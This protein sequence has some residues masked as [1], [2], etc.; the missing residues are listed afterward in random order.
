M[1]KHRTKP[2]GTAAIAALGQ[3]PP[4][5]TG[6]PGYGDWR[7]DGPGVRRRINAADMPPPYETTSANQGPT[8]VARPAD[9]WPKAPPGFAVELF[10]SGG[11]DNPREITPVEK[12]AAL[13][14]A[15][16]PMHLL[17]IRQ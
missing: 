11:L 13:D 10:V 3:S 9:A 15:G 17:W 14:L 16:E 6:A 1:M 7:S 12:S 8:V 2:S 5:L 4:V